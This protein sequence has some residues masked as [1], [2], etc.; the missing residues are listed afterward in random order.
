[1]T[2][3]KKRAIIFLPYQIT[4]RDTRAID[5]R[6]EPLTTALFFYNFKDPLNLCIFAKL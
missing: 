2:P 6:E 3:Q 5:K 1:M 4:D